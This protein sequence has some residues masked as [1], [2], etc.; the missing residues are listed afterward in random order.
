MRDGPTV[1]SASYR[2]CSGCKFHDRKM[3]MSGLDPVYEHFCKHPN[4]S[5]DGPLSDLLGRDRLIGRSDHTP[6]WCPLIPGEVRR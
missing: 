4:V 2:S 3:L 5:D 6:G 1:I